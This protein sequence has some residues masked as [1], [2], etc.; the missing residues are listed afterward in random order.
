MRRIL[1]LSTYP[2]VK[3]VHGGQRRVNAF[4]Q[5]LE[6]IG[7]EFHYASV[8]EGAHY[9]KALTTKN[10]I[11]L[12]YIGAEWRN[13]PLVGDL[14]S[15]VFAETAPNA[16][17]HFLTIFQRVAP[18][19]IQLEQPFLW[20]VVR[21]IR[22][23]GVCSDTPV[24]YSSQNWE[25]PLKY[26]MLIKSDV[27]K[28]K[29]REV[30]DYI[31][32]LERELVSASAAVVT[33]SESDAEQY[34]KIAPETPIFV[35]PNGVSR[36]VDPTPDA[37]ELIEIYDGEKYLLFVG[38]AYPPNIEGFVNLVLKKG[39]FF[40]PP[41]KSLAICGGVS[42]GVFNDPRYQSLLHANSRRVQFFPEVTDHG[43]EALKRGSHA[44]LLPIQ[45]GGG[46]NL[47]T[48]EALASGK[49]VVATSVAMRGFSEFIGQ[50]GVIIADTPDAFRSA[51]IEVLAKP[52]LKLSKAAAKLRETVYWDHGFKGS[53]YLDFVQRHARQTQDR[54]EHRQ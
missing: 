2:I 44:I 7:W 20:P 52:P 28:L 53:G 37:Q 50:P 48:A 54:G 22:A 3:P 29:A 26:E 10:D 25:A 12:H 43:L 21:A 47:K 38:S 15:G 16:Y 6:S 31:I 32:A 4:S 46:S 39:L 13:M 17:Q 30:Y 41:V 40:R 34:R 5:Q 9:P 27:A 18:D 8:Y 51:I 1:S 24:I 11:P 42:H 23:A 36:P 14:Q 19:I 35:V 33:V 45:F 49:W